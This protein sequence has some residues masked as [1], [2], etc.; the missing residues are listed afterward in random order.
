MND[1]LSSLSNPLSLSIVVDASN[2]ALLDGLEVWLRLGLINDDYVK[3]FSQLYLTSPLPEPVTVVSP[4]KT[5][6]SN[7]PET[8]LKSE[9][10][11]PQK[12]QPRNIFTRI[13][14][15]LKDELSVRWLLF[16][17]LFLVVI[18]ST[19]LAATQW[20]RFTN[21]G[22]YLILWSYTLVF[23]GTGFWLSRQENLQ[24]TSQTL[25]NIAFLLIPINFWAMDTFR[26][27]EKQWGWEVIALACFSLTLVFYQYS[28]SRHRFLIAINF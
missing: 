5:D 3:Q 21:V 4:Q 10:I 23:W 11:I 16:L 13:L 19:L 15:G 7:I 27:W 17:G 2:P 8:P 1:E 22:Q 25:Q 28:K 24:L 9:Q 18:S 14:Q 6:L 26:L 12:R 20:Q